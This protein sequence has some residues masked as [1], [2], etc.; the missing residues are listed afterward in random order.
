M[1]DH[2]VQ[3]AGY[4]FLAAPFVV[5][6]Y[7]ELKL[8]AETD[9]DKKRSY[10]ELGKQKLQQKPNDLP[11][12]GELAVQAAELGLFNEAIELWD[13][14]LRCAP[15]ATIAYFNKGFALMNLGRYAEALECSRRALELDPEHKEAAYN[16]GTCE[17]YVGEPQRALTAIGLIVAK[18]PEYPLL[19]ALRAALTCACGNSVEVAELVSALLKNGY[20]ID[21]YFREQTTMLQR[22]GRD[23]PARRL[24]QH[25]A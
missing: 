7:G 13:S 18:H 9:L 21:A 5:H 1:L 4:S 20:A 14:F 23:E 25:A 19:Q 17:L 8:R 22:L 24:E 11:A 3:Q 10:Y 6:H 12:I 2:A 16:Y 15:D